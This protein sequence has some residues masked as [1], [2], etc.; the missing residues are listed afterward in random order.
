MILAGRRAARKATWLRAWAGLAGILTWGILLGAGMRLGGQTV[1][2]PDTAPATPPATSALAAG[3][4]TTAAGGNTTVT[5]GDFMALQ[6][7]YVEL[8]NAAKPA[9]VKVKILASTAM[10]WSP[11]NE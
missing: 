3:N 1:L 6:R 8:F 11:E 4:E 10:I 7:R 9:V 5:G 2:I